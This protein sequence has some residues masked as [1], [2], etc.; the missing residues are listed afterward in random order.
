MVGSTVDFGSYNILT[1]GL[2][3]DTTFEVLGFEI[4]AA[5]L[6]SVFLAITGNFVLNKYWTFRDTDTDVV[7]QWS[8]Y[9]ALNT[10]TFVLNQI[11]T[12]FFA[13]QV[14]LVALVFG[15]MKDNAAKAMAIG[16]ILFVNFFGSK[17]FIFRKKGE[18][19][20]VP[21]A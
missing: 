21:V 7:K 20:S 1:R 10:A 19:T 14:P 9:F 15:G 11:I 6:V 16:M 5:N 18:A 13:F 12:S 3:W 4:I 2:G 8:S 17:F